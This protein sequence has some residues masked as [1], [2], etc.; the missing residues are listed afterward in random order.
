MSGTLSGHTGKKTISAT[1]R[2]LESLIRLSE[3]HARVRLAKEVTEDDV[4]EAIRL[5]NV[6]T[7]SA[8]IDQKTGLID[9]DMINTGRGTAERERCAQL[10]D[11]IKDLLG[12][13]HKGTKSM[14]M[15]QLARR[16]E[17]CRT[18]AIIIAICFFRKRWAN[19]I[20]E[21]VPKNREV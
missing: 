17:K 1:P 13:K 3:A 18:P 9:M 19:E 10:A 14:K 8:A 15:Y 11:A 2:Q 7:H 5:M 12:S 4:A 16:L 21:K 20:M 6:S